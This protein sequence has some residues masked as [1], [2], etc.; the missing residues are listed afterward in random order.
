[1]HQGRDA[2][3]RAHRRRL[4]L[5]VPDQQRPLGPARNAGGLGQDG[6]GIERRR[7][8]QR[9]GG[10]RLGQRVGQGEDLQGAGTG[11]H[12]RDYPGG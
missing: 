10:R 1:M 4:E 9:P 5:E 8:V 7:L 2:G 12:A 6:I 3:R 11:F